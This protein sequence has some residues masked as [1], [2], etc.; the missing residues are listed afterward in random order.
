MSFENNKVKNL[1]KI[2]V[3]QYAANEGDSDTSAAAVANNS[4]VSWDQLALSMHANSGAASSTGEH[5]MDL[6]FE[7]STIDTTSSHYEKDQK[8]F[9]DKNIISK[10]DVDVVLCREL[11]R[12]RKTKF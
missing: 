2:L 4:S 9:L 6:S 8:Q 11:F 5:G 3:E 12:I 10:C 7:N 1:S